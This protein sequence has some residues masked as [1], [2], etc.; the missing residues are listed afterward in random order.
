MKPFGIHNYPA[1]FGVERTG[2]TASVVT[3][4]FM[5]LGDIRTGMFW[6]AAN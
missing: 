1:I 6:R 2:G 5:P 3:G 4:V